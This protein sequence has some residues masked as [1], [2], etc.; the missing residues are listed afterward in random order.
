MMVTNEELLQLVYKF[1][2][3]KPSAGNTLGGA[4]IRARSETL[5]TRKKSSIKSEIM[6]NQQLTEDLHKPIVRKFEKRK[7]PSSFK[8]NVLGADA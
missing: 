6:S 2:T 4:V 5:A 8:N 1:F 3:K 7:V